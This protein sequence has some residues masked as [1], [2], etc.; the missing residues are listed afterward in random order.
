MSLKYNNGRV[1][2]AKC[3]VLVYCE[4]FDVLFLVLA[5][6]RPRRYAATVPS[7]KF[8]GTVRQKNVVQKS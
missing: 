4:A 6:R 1:F 7:A 2:N 3:Q 5:D 8:I